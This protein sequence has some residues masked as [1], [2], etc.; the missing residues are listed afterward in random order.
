MPHIPWTWRGRYGAALLMVALGTLWVGALMALIALPIIYVIA[1]LF[2]TIGTGLVVV[3]QIAEVSNGAWMGGHF[4]PAHAM[5]DDF[6]S[7]VKAMAIGVTVIVTGLY[8]GYTVRGR[9]ARSSTRCR[10][11]A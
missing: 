1:M 5:S 10:C 6:L 2:G 9:S 3:L 8:Y 4:G 7:M 11:S